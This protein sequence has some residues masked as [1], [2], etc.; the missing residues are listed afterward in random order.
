MNDVSTVKVKNVVD[1][2][3]PYDIGYATGYSMGK[4]IGYDVG[5][6]ECREDYRRKLREQREKEYV[7]KK[8]QLYFLKQKL[9]GVLFLIITAFTVMLLEGDATIAVLTVPIGVGLI[10]SKEKCLVNKYYFETAPV[11]EHKRE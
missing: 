11:Y 7:K 1:V 3:S 9:I 8:R 5:Y 2:A 4:V 10:F 6:E